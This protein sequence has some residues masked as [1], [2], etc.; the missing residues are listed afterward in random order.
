MFKEEDLVR[1]DLWSAE[2]LAIHDDALIAHF[3][4][5]WTRAAD[6]QSRLLLHRLIT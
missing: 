3:A 2:V 5:L 6:L 4:R 1:G